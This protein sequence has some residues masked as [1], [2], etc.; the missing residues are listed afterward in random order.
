MRSL[1]SILKIKWQ[2]R[3]TNLMVLDRA[4]MSSIEAIIIKNQLRWVGHVIHMDD[5]RLLKQLLYGKLSSGKHNT[6]RP[7]KRFKDY[8]KSY[9]IHTGIRPKK[10]E[11]E[12]S[13]RIKWQSLIQQAQ[14]SLEDQRREKMTAA[15]ARRKASSAQPATPG[16]FPCTRICRSRIGTI[17]HLRTHI[18][19]T[20]CPKP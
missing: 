7:R 1:R 13:N 11:Q 15:R 18:S 2:D 3:V 20:S 6:G 19:N 16:Q 12:V 17:S 10:L 9:I 5:H 4:E 14:I 8:V